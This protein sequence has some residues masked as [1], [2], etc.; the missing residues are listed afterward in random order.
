M[1]FDEVWARSVADEVVD[2]LFFEDRPSKIYKIS[3]SKL[4][5]IR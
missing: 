2:E 1:K 5:K 4:K 3:K